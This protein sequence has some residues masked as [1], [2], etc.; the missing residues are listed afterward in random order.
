MSDE[1]IEAAVEKATEEQSEKSLSDVE[2]VEIVAKITDPKGTLLVVDGHSLAFRAFYA[3]PVEN[4]SNGDG[5]ATNSVYGFIT[6]LADVVKKEKPTHIGVAFDV[7]GGT[8]RN[9][10]L[11]Q[12][13]GT[14]SAAPEELL[15]QIPLIQ[16][17]LTALNIPTIEKPGYEGDDVIA[18]LATQAEKSGYR[19]LVLS[20]DRDAFQLVDD[21]VTVLYPGQH[22]KDLKHMTPDAVLEKY[23]VSPR[24]Y[25]DIAALRGEQADNIPGV[26]GVGDG[27]AA[28][29]INQYGGLQGII[30]HA[31][32][33]GGK[34][35]A[36]LRENI[37]Q[38]KLNRV[39]N[40]VV[41]NLDLGVSFDELKITTFD[42]AALDAVLRKLQFGTRTRTN[43][44]TT[45]SA[46]AGQKAEALTKE[47]SSG[48]GADSADAAGLNDQPTGPMNALD[49]LK[50]QPVTEP[51]DDTADADM[52][53]E[54]LSQW[55]SDHAGP[56]TALLDGD[57]QPGAAKLENIAFLAADRHTV[58]VPASAITGESRVGK[59]CSGDSDA[60]RALRTE[61]SRVL[62]ASNITLY[63]YKESLLL[64]HSARLTCARPACDVRLAA[65]IIDPDF[66]DSTL[67][68]TATHFLG[69]DFSSG[70][71]ESDDASAAGRA[72]KTKPTQM[73]FDLGPLGAA[74]TPDAP[75]SAGRD[76][77]D[78]SRER[79][80]RHARLLKKL[81]LIAALRATLM[82]ALKKRGQESLLAGI[83][84]P[85][86]QILARMEETG[87]AVDF[88][89]LEH[90]R[91]DF[92]ARAEE[93]RRVAIETAGPG[94]E[95][96]NL[97]SPKQLSAVLFGDDGFA[98]T[99]TK[100]TR[101]GYTTNAA[102]LQKLY[103]MTA[104][105]PQ[106]DPR[107]HEFLAALLQYREVNKLKQI[108]ETL[109]EA[110]NRRDGRIHTTYE[111]TV[112]ATGRL[113]ST[114][115][116]LQN[117][118]MRTEEGRVIRG[119]FV[120]AEPTFA[121]LLSADYSQVELRIMAHLSGDEALID[122]FRSGADFHRYVAS[123][124]YGIPME[125]VS[126]DQR[127]HVKAMSYG[128]AY[129]LSTFGLAQRLAIAPAQA[130]EL[131]DKYFSVFGKVH[132][133]LES[134]VAQARAKGYT[135]TMFG[136][137]R[138][139]P[140]L[141]ARQFVRRQAA[142]RA[143]LNA[144]IQGTAADIMKIAMIKA[145]KALDEAGVRSRIILQIHDELVVEL[146]DGEEE[147]VASLVKDAMEHA[148][149]LSVPLNVSTGIGGN[150][151]TA[152]H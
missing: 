62:S 147:Q 56:M 81:A 137:R 63:G 151:Q 122:A 47:D 65:Y 17:L 53:A 64:A 95:S 19:A 72:R 152:A 31:D 21:N 138:Y 13:K 111:Q 66:A 88:D 12:Y 119:A 14:R 6:M 48:A 110:V 116:N 2:N 125:E 7:K 133:Y 144:P 37:E 115:P 134:L 109:K 68:K 129:G 84:L 33:I 80:Y 106:V 27:Y 148:V 22:F 61:C 112:A 24:Q 40:A 34:K 105:N 32:E 85:V 126:G 38:V 93:H 132:D 124:V 70:G 131:T 60:A 74:A 50:P 139:F 98:L 118:P 57:C 136:R 135:E 79:A 90:L 36:A 107:A 92:A 143:A 100:K 46:N 89:L 8:F 114:A 18:S 146:A 49:G 42:Q 1:E 35:G 30:E 71:S 104:V 108:V 96:L 94:H 127:T 69:D 11:P 149:E 44:I 73:G 120:A 145:Q 20:G 141:R 54:Q 43:I 23:K 55:V 117:I 150:W 39:I 25:P 52:D 77:G 123:L 5:Q 130:R 82:P 140:D 45:F 87:A 59:S 102:A 4:F 28:K 103:E 121:N 142:E 51:I 15:T 78:D 9:R 113:S 58:V 10:A 101:S 41:R 83:E 91:N 29:W 16:E 75:G 26:P 86:S 76:D 97:Q 128:L 67:E 99:G 3:L